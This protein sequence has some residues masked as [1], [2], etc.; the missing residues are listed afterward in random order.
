MPSAPTPNMN[1]IQPTVNGDYNTWGSELNGTIT[2]IDGHTHEVGSGVP[3]TPLG[4]NINSDLSFQSN[5]ANLVRSVRLVNAGS[6]YSGAG[7]IANVYVVSGNLYY[8]NGAGVPVQI[9]NG[10]VVNSSATA[11]TIFPQ[12]T[13]ASN[14]SILSSATYIE[15]LVQT[16]SGAW[17]ISLPA[18]SSVAAGRYF[19]IKDV[20][21]NAALHNI[22]LSPNG[23]DTIDNT[24]SFVLLYNYSSCFIVS[25]GS[26]NWNVLG[27]QKNT[28]NSNESVT[29]NAGALSTYNAQSGLIM[30]GTQ[31]FNSGSNLVGN[32]GST[33]TW[34][35]GSTTTWAS[36]ADGYFAS[37]SL[38][39]VQGTG[40]NNLLNIGNAGS[41]NM[42]NGSTLNFNS[43]HQ[44]TGQITW[45][46]TQVNPE[47]IQASISTAA[48]HHMYLHAQST[49]FANAQGGNLILTPGSFGTGGTSGAIVVAPAVEQVAG[50]QTGTMVVFPF[51]YTQ[52]LNTQ[53]QVNAYYPNTCRTTYGGGNVTFMTFPMAN[54]SACFIDVQWI[55]RGTTVTTYAVGG[56]GGIFA[57]CSSSGVTNGSANPDV[58]SS[59]F[60]SANIAATYTAN[61]IT[62]AAVPTAENDT[63][64]W[65]IIC[66]VTYE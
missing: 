57:S 46:N 56:K 42:N 8:N 50:S 58:Y 61:T 11:A 32:S 27:Q 23:S 20:T 41:L 4:L 22:T 44:I 25:D 66:N 59:S 51:L 18:A 7:D 17:T 54:S 10:T 28:Y 49:T 45:V 36:G 53:R 21:G 35:S 31:Y 16:T 15:V 55:C 38:F 40:A 6:T 19:I 63:L 26:G 2:T 5:N 48:G 62:L 39:Q 37:G 33:A 13:A 43:G 29:Y 3:I 60:N 52:S 9:T 64:D 34:S 24:S 65:T 1:L 12:T 47:L 14:F 30:A